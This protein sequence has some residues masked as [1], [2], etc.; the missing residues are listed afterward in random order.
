[1][2]IQTFAP[3]TSF[4][5]TNAG[6]SVGGT[7]DDLFSQMLDQSAARATERRPE[8]H[9]PKP[10]TPER[11]EPAR[12]KPAASRPAARPE[13]WDPPPPAAK[14]AADHAPSRAHRADEAHTANDA[15]KATHAEDRVAKPAEKDTAPARPAEGSARTPKPATTEHG[16][17]TETISKP[18]AA[19]KVETI[20]AVQVA[21]AE[22]SSDSNAVA[23]TPAE[24]PLA[25]TDP[26]GL[27]VAE[28]EPTIAETTVQPISADGTATTTPRAETEAQAPV[29]IEIEAGAQVQ[30]EA[31][32][33]SAPGT[34]TPDQAAAAAAAAGLQANTG[35][36]A[37][38][39]PEAQD[40]LATKPIDA[41]AGTPPARDPAVMP[42]ASTAM[43]GTSAAPAEPTRAFAAE[44]AAANPKAEAVPT[45]AMTPAATKATTEA[46]P[47]E[48]KPS[49][50]DAD[51]VK[52]PNSLAD[53]VNAKPSEKSAD[54][55]GGGAQT[56]SRQD[57]DGA[58]QQTATVQTPPPAQRTAEIVTATVEATAV[59]AVAGVQSA[60]VDAAGNKDPGAGHILPT[61]AVKAAAPAD[62]PSAFTLRPV[63]GPHAPMGVQEQI[64]VN[65]HKHV[66]EGNERFTIML[67]PEELGRIDIRLEI[68]ADGRVSALVAV[69]RPQT[70]DLLM[71]DSRGLERAL[72]EAGL[73]ADSNSLS[74]SL[75]DDGASSFADQR[76]DDRRGAGR[77]G[78]GFGG[79]DDAPEVIA[80]QPLTL[81][82]GRVDVRV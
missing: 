80:M 78:R 13:R 17:T 74:F 2:E 73:K 70:L 38:L 47:G 72:Q 29:E 33:A 9:K 27:V 24:A 64:A 30:A 35:A 1:M 59:D 21:K 3:Q 32:I 45:D 23:E 55:S 7:K 67:R 62:A 76:G 8:P 19:A 77:R 56:E 57:G 46:T 52:L 34:V 71:R 49:K 75:R 61:D 65:I 54:R 68:G 53:L 28:A 26:T 63:R 40:P 51:E 42:D 12:D 50:A 14:P 22:V 39:Q 5:P 10:R 18:D 41:A 82:P 11:H 69:D 48:A 81:G 36:P 20:D 25:G 43:P 60:P 6:S 79:D 16:G 44:L 37:P 66:A 4:D 58:P 15:R 31:D